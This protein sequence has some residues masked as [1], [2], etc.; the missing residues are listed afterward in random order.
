M[1]YMKHRKVKYITELGKITQ[2]KIT[3]LTAT[4][5]KINITLIKLENRVNV[6]LYYV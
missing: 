3:W 1:H 4:L 6:Q 5:H 2:H